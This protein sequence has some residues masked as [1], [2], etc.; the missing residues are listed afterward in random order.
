MK[1]LLAGAALSTLISLAPVAAQAAPGVTAAAPM[2]S[3]AAIV[4]AA[5]GCGPGGF[6]DRFGRCFYR[7]P[8]PPPFRRFCPPGTHPTPYGCRRNF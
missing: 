1:H 5:E 6:R 7:R 3:S 8:G 2:S 4:L